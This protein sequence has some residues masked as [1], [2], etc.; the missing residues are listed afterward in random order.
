MGSK[1]EQLQNSNPPEVQNKLSA[2]L[3][4]IHIFVPKH[5]SEN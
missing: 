4:A 3:I 5:N 2:D 1:S